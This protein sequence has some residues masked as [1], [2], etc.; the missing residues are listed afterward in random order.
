MSGVPEPVETLDAAINQAARLLSSKPT[1][2]AER[3]LEIL[4]TSPNHPLATLLL[5][6][7]RRNH[8]AI[9][10]A[11]EILE[12]LA[13]AHPRWAP[14]HYE[15]GVT[16]GIAGRPAQAVA[17][18]RRAVRLK[19]DI[20]DA[21]R[22]I[23][24]YLIE[25]GD[26]AGADLAY[27]N[28]LAVST[29]DPR[30][31]APAAAICEDRIADAETLL[32]AHLEQHPTDAVALRMLAEAVARVGR[33]ADAED[34]LARC[35]AVAPGFTPARY[36]Y[37]VVLAKQNKTA[38]SLAEI[39]K[40]LAAEPGNP[41]Y[42]NLQANALTRIGEY[43]QAIDAFAAV[44][45]D[46]PSNAKIWLAYGHA[47]KTAGHRGDCITAYRRGIELAPALGEAY[48][49]LANLK[50]FR[51]APSDIDAMRAQLARAD[52]SGEDRV[53]FHFALGK[54]LEDAGDYAGS[55]EQYAEGNRVRRA[56][57]LQG[58]YV[59]D[60]TTAYVRRSKGLFS[61]DFFR[62]REGWGCRDR[63]PIFIVG[64]P[65]S[66][67]TLVEQILSSHSMVE[68]TMEL[69][70]VG[71]ITHSLVDRAKQSGP[72]LY[73]EVVANLGADEFRALGERY[74]RQTRIQRKSGTP[75]F[76]DKMPNNWAHVGLI[77]LMLPNAKI[78]DARRHPLSCCFSNF[79]QHFSRG[80]HFTY[81]LEDVGRF[82]RDYVDL[83]AHFDKVL[84]GRIHRVI[85]ER[86]VEDTETEIRRLLAYCDLPFED[87]CLRFYETDRAVRTPSSEQ[88]RQP[89]FRDGVERWRHYEPWLDPLKEALGPVLAA[90]PANPEP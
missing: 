32:R 27:A 18:L 77:H 75:F 33:Y 22:L 8:G 79:K 83:M 81:S 39:G 82:Y 66:G 10:A 29:R 20:G 25:M 58:S 17:S 85:Y 38:E 76:I 56:G 23:A 43:D 4:R 13:G 46:Y 57:I 53:H 40:L 15:L 11:I 35:L 45:A 72:S 6:M 67:S 88:V 68:G 90:Y 9:V 80:Q 51:F 24:D 50:T 78:I 37:A 49:S 26:P 86:M 41:S 52:L 1:L 71:Q 19:P 54:A 44:L 21:W 16:F 7:A 12:P 30:L 69:H 28:H 34:L 70:D 42:L 36:N 65:R 63:D 74:L 31:I 84:P 73:P 61:A 62:Q 89:I 64:L 14:V 59:A 55:F 48:F 2:A 60:E 5:G 3:A 47:L 87:A